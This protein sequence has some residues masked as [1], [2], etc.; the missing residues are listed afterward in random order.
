MDNQIPTSGE[1]C[2]AYRQDPDNESSLSNF[3]KQRH[4]HYRSCMSQAFTPS[5]LKDLEDQMLTYVTKFV[6]LVGKDGV[7]REYSTTAARRD[8]KPQ[9]SNGYDL[10]EWC[11]YMAFHV[12]W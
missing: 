12:R 2:L 11:S 9:W 8:P 6:D 3:S 10:A 4:A 1:F 5:A 7:P